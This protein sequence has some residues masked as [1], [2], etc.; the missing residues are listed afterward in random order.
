MKVETALRAI[1]AR[2]EPDLEDACAL[3]C[4]E[5]MHEAEALTGSP[6][7]SASILAAFA[8]AKTWLVGDLADLVAV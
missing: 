5:A 3:A 4:F 8:E 6:D 1:A 2:P 7:A